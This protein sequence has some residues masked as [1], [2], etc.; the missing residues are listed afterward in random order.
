MNKAK[1]I[2]EFWRREYSKKIKKYDAFHISEHFK[3]VAALFSPGLTYFYVLN[4]HNLELDFVSPEVEDFVGLPPEEVNIEKLL[5]SALPQELEW[6]EK[7]EKVVKDF[8]QDFLKK[9]DPTRYKLVY[10]YKMRDSK[11]NKRVILHQA[12]PPYHSRKWFYKTCLEYTF[13]HFTYYLKNYKNSIIH[14]SCRP[15]S[16]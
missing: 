8:Y 6:V 7:K 11:N 12:T 4:V 5:G 15:Q 13:R 10:T 14:R 3:K 2:S 16:F 1:R 9:S